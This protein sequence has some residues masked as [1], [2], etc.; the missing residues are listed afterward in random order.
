MLLTLV[1]APTI[2]L[3]QSLFS[4]FVCC[5]VYH[6]CHVLWIED[7]SDDGANNFIEELFKSILSY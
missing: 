4:L 3:S 7:G 1:T 6:H 5:F 2:T